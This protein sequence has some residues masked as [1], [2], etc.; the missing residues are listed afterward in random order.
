MIRITDKS[1]CSGCTACLAVCPHQAISMKPDALGFLYPEVDTD[2]C[3]DCGLCEKACDFVCSS[4]IV[5]SVPD[6]IHVYAAMNKD[7]SVLESSQSGGV[8]SALAKKI[9]YEGGT[10]YGA[11]FN[12]DFTVSHMR[13][14]TL[15]GCRAFR[16]SKYVQSNLS[17]VFKKV[18]RDL[19]QG[20]KV[21]FTG[22]PCQTAGLTA[23][24]PEHLRT[25]LLAVDFICHGVPSP[26][27]WRDYVSYMKRKGELS[28][29]S[30]RDKSVGGWKI[31]AES[32]AYADGRKVV[33][34]T[35]K[36]MYYKNVMLRHSCA[37]CPYDISRR[38]GDLAIADFWGLEEAMPHLD[39]VQGASMV[40]PFTE[41]GRLVLEEVSADLYLEK[42]CLTPDF[43]YRRN[44]NLLRPSKIYHERQMFEDMYPDKGF[45]YAARRWGDMGWRYK[46][47][48]LKSFIRKITGLK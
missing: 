17:D 12:P 3:T 8:F 9:I 37:S 27:V 33:R 5:A 10:V 36:V 14:D 42:V 39:G 41:K 43:I 40:L 4:S 32:F 25:G 1:M 48:M 38:R 47:W 20:R 19:A 15:E 45:M 34:E 46:A 18:R 35:Y 21:L 7:A 44:P 13:A 11:A 29:V 28:S 24:L 22:T 23:F 16:G 31:H 6:E 2:R 30:F 26:F